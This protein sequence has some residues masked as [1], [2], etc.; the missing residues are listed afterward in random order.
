MQLRIYAGTWAAAHAPEAHAMHGAEVGCRSSRGRGRTWLSNDPVARKRQSGEKA[1]LYT[2]S[3]WRRSVCRQ[4]PRSASQSRTVVSND[5]VASSR[6]LLGLGDLGLGA[7]KRD[8]RNGVDQ[9]GCK[10]F[11]ERLLKAAMWGDASLGANRRNGRKGVAARCFI[12]GCC[13]R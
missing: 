11:H 9:K 7:N 6:G 5:A 2:L 1:T 13:K 4:A 3:T 8:G 10:A 12:R